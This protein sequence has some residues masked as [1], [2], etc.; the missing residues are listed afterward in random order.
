MKTF[1]DL[2]GSYEGLRVRR[3]RHS[4]RLML[5]QIVND[6][7]WL[8]VIKAFEPDGRDKALVSAGLAHPS[9]V[10]AWRYV[11]LADAEAKF[12]QLK[13]FYPETNRIVSAATLEKLRRHQFQPK[14][15]R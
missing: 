15:P 13:P 5:Y 1:F 6:P 4:G 7:Y 12:D 11:A 9:K 2:T 10:G 8:V 14:I 3:L